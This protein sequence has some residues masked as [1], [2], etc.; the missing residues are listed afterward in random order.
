M[1]QAYKIKLT[2]RFQQE[3][4]DILGFIATS[5]PNN[6]LKFRNELYAQIATLE[7]MPLRCRRHFANAD[8][9]N[10]NIRELIFKGYAVVFLVDENALNIE[11]LGI[12]KANEWRL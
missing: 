6:A 7:F 12:Y 10:E 11:I 2:D 4:H 5:N 1:V 9:T 3:L 8:S